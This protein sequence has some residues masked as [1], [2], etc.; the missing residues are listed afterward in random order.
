VVRITYDRDV[1][2]LYIR[3]KETTVT[4]DRV[5]EGIAL[6][7]DA[8]DSLAGIEILDARKRLDCRESS[9]GFGL[10]V[11][12]SHEQTGLRTSPSLQLS[13]NQMQVLDALRRV[14][15]EEYRLGDWYLGALYA[16]ENP[17][18]PGRDGSPI[19][20]THETLFAIGFD[21]S[22]EVIT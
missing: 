10:G 18:D 4:T 17:F 21:D 3:L 6:D 7:Y 9:K 2:A 19:R 16:L 5:E 13:T 8:A 11:I 20:E 15:T 14:E 1:D 12:E 22:D